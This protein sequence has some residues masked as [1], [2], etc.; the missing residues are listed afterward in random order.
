[1]VEKRFPR[2]LPYIDLIVGRDDPVVSISDY[3]KAGGVRV[4]LETQED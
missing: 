3:Q 1:V 2:V 4:L